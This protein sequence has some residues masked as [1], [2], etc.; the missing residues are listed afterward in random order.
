MVK[1]SLIIIISLTLGLAPAI[2]AR[3]VIIPSD[4]PTIQEGINS[5]T[6]GD[7]V[8]VKPGTYLENINFNGLNIVVASFFLIEGDPEYITETIID[9]DSAGSVVTF[10]NEEDSTAIIT[11]FTIT[12]GYYMEGGGIYC[13]GSGP[14]I[15]SNI[16]SEN[17]VVYYHNGGGIYCSNSYAKIIDNAIVENHACHGGGIYCE[18]S[19]VVIRNNIIANNE[20][21]P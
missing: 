14:V 8:L 10:E 5:C 18:Y 11:G 19:D 7:T 4:Y 9:G 12:N 17:S 21:N 16:I 1:K 3:T 15:S 2:I 13:E 20:A 6:D